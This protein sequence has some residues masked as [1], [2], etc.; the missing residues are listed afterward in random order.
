ML[1]LTVTQVAGGFALELT[2]GENIQPPDGVCRRAVATTPRQAGRRAAEL[3][4]A[5]L[6]GAKR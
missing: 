4:E 6:T 2:N 5:E 3:I 1:K